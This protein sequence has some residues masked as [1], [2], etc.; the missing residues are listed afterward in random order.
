ML[1]LSHAIFW[2]LFKSFNDLASR[3]SIHSDAQPM[4]LVESPNL[5]E[6]IR[7]TGPEVLY[8]KTGEGHLCLNPVLKEQTMS[9]Q[10]EIQE[11]GIIKRYPV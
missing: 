3:V 11:R 2:N 7:S 10:E 1:E 8:K 9:S 6:N 5:K 4:F